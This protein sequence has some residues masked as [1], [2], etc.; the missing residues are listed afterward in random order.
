MSETENKDFID[1]IWDYFLKAWRFF[2]FVL[3]PILVVVYL[4]WE[5]EIFYST[6]SKNLYF[7]ERVVFGD[8]LFEKN[9]EINFKI[10]PETQTI[11][12]TNEQPIFN[13]KFKKIIGLNRDC[14]LT[15]IIKDNSNKKCEISDIDK[16]KIS[17]INSLPKF[18]QSITKLENCLIKDEENWICNSDI[19]HISL[20]I[21]FFGLQNGDWIIDIRYE[22]NIK[23]WKFN[24]YLSK[25][26]CGETCYQ[27]SSH[28]TNSKVLK[29]SIERLKQKQQD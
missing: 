2:E 21:K 6:D 26:E 22:D 11:I 17:Y 4:I 10:Y 12:Q 15:N 28:K 5:F 16:D 27:T 14:I 24:W 7:T 29:H 13:E 23:N 25:F 1:K 8:S 18:K 19:K 20:P 3:L 9:H